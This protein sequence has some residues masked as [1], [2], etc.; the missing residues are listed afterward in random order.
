MN[1]S[2]PDRKLDRGKAAGEMYHLRLFVAGDE[3]NSRQARKNLRRICENHLKG[4]YA[5]E[6]VDVLEDFKTAQASG[7]L[8]TPA[9]FLVAPPPPVTI[10][11]TLSDAQKVLAALRLTEGEP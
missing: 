11:G 8:V 6:I 1:R 4:H 3:L 10:L 9:L 2:D 5:L 7:V